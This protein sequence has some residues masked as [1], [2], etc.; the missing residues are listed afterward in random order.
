MQPSVAPGRPAHRLTLTV[1]PSPP[2]PTAVV[3]SEAD[4]NAR[5]ARSVFSSSSAV[6]TDPRRVEP[7][8]QVGGQP[9]LVA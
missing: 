2:P 6:E 4:S 3:S 8:V 9:C 5:W 1:G 7:V